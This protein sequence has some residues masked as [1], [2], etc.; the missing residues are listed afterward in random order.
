MKD[1]LIIDL[2]SYTQY[3]AKTWLFIPCILNQLSI[4]GSLEELNFVYGL[5]SVLYLSSSYVRCIESYYI[6][7]YDGFR[8][9]PNELLN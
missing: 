7:F 3:I 5:D 4:L 8:I 1:F 6:E 2:I 9:A